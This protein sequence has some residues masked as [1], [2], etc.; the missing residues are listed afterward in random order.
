MNFNCDAVDMSF[1]DRQ[2]LDEQL[3]QA[4]ERMSIDVT[5]KG[6]PVLEAMLALLTGGEFT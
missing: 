2:L 4:L 6:N 3:I 5:R 1:Y